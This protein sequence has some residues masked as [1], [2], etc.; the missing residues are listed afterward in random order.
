MNET[1]TTLLAD[2][3][4]FFGDLL[5]NLESARKAFVSTSL[6]EDEGVTVRTL[7]EATIV[8]GTLEVV[9]Q[10]MSKLV[11][12]HPSLES[13]FEKNFGS[14]RE[15]TSR[16][17]L[18]EVALIDEYL[19][20][21]T[22]QWPLNVQDGFSQELATSYRESF[23]GWAKEVLQDHL[24]TQERIK[25]KF[26]FKLSSGD[27]KCQCVQCL[28][29]YRTKL[30]EEV[31]AQQEK[32]INDAEERLYDMVLTRSITDVSNYVFNLRK[33]M[34]R[35]INNVRA[36][37]KRS[38][39]N[40]IES[41]VKAIFR[42]KFAGNSPLGK[43]YREKLMV[44][45]N[46]CLVEQGLKPEMISPSEYERFFLQQE[47]GI[48]KPEGF[49]KKEFEKFTRSVMLLKRKDISSTILRDYLGQFWVHAEARKINR[50]IIYHMGPTNSGK[51][52]HAIQA[53]TAAKKGCYLA[54]LRLLAAELFDTM[55]QKGAVTTL[56]TGEEVIEIPGSTH[57][58]S[59]IEMARLNERFDCAVIDEIQMLADPQRGWAWTRA[60]VSLQAD[61]VHLCGDRSVLELVKQIL[62]LTGDTLEVKEYNRMT[63]LKV[64]DNTITLADLERGDALIVFSRRNALKFKAD[65]ENLDFKVSIVYGRLSPE[66]RREQA[67]KF[68]FGE[69]DIIVSTDAIAMGMNLPVQRI[70]FSALSKFIDNKEIPL[71][72]S[73]IK[74]IAG[75]A[76]R[77]GR[78][79][80]GYTTTLNRVDGGL[81]RL[82]EALDT[83]LEQSTKA[84][85]GPDLEIFKSVNSA[86]EMNSLPVLSLS[87]FLR[88]FNT[89]SFERPFF[90]TDLKEMIEIT[91]MVEQEDEHNKLS[92]TEIFGFACAPVNLGLIEHVQYFVWILKHYVDS[93][94]IFSESIDFTSDDIDYLET[95]IKCV[96]LY[97]WLSRHFAGK[98]FDF[99][100]AKLLENKAKAVEK[101][102]GLLSE[103]TTKSCASCGCKL[104]MSSRFAICDNC[105]M[106]RKNARRGG[107]GMRSEGRDDRPSYENNGNRPPREDREGSRRDDRGGRRRRKGFKGHQQQRDDRPRDDRPRDERPRED[108][109]ARPEG[110]GLDL[111]TLRNNQNRSSVTSRPPTGGKRAASAFTGIGGG[112]AGGKSAKSRRGGGNAKSGAGSGK[113]IVSPSHPG[114]SGE[115]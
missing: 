63:E 104:S 60:L 88:L 64:M 44:F 37:F 9:Y 35:G 70:V 3:R 58:S 31:M 106:A 45:F 41:E 112:P 4:P 66:V 13:I 54:P 11:N 7:E 108:R 61:E 22:D 56:L 113:R 67:R 14:L 87:E 2:P 50:K 1:V 38:S 55:N 75:R 43:V 17:A 40:K 51:T 114:S 53:L 72:M 85:V 101:L 98:N 30:R 65:L 69:T 82:Q 102:N 20:P 96:E 6:S 26:D 23:Q 21:R 27:L 24:A 34:E 42:A 92:S 32:M 28:G 8:L 74:Q 68:D 52:Y 12:E 78:F 89:M 29:D 103:K 59:T 111:N 49:L 19:F 110:S 71:T 73:E 94:P 62:K 83:T 39:L 25:T 16:D 80:T 99:V 48:W 47:T 76:G 107:G 79:P 95:S 105:F 15:I 86:L 5:Q 100:E 109:P 93:A 77:F 18:F 115:S 36:K 33:N 90:C 57:Y 10:E 46:T 91:E 84:M 97:Q 81:D